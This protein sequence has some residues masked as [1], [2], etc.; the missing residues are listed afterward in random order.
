MRCGCGGFLVKTSAERPRSGERRSRAAC[1]PRWV[2]DDRGELLRSGSRPRRDGDLGR[3]LRRRGSGTTAGAG[4]D[5][6]PEGRGKWVYAAPGRPAREKAEQYI[7]KRVRGRGWNDDS[8]SSGIAAL[9]RSTPQGY[10]WHLLEAHLKGH[11][12]TGRLQKARVV[13]VVEPGPF[14]R[15]HED[16]VKH[17]FVCGT[18]R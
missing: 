11:Y 18:V 16:S 8:F 1:S 5:I 9:P 15:E 12:T 17:F 14:C 3:R 4:P 7:R 2:L 10:R 6:R 13:E